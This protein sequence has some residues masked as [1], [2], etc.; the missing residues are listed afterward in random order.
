MKNQEGKL[1]ADKASYEK[2]RP[3]HGLALIDLL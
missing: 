2:I 1:N 3:V